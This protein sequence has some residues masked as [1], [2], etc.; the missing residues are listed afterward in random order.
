ME[1]FVK[2]HETQ[3]QFLGI[4]D[5]FVPSIQEQLQ[6]AYVAD[7]SWHHVAWNAFYVERRISFQELESSDIGFHYC[8]CRT[9]VRGI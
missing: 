3:L 7:N 5:V 6:R 2:L 1:A 9:S 8:H 4:P